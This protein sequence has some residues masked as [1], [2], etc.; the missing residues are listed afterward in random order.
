M[1]IALVLPVVLIGLL[2]GMVYLT[3]SWLHKCNYQPNFVGA[4]AIVANIVIVLVIIRIM[5]L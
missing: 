2:V 4:L 3:W 1:W 5:L